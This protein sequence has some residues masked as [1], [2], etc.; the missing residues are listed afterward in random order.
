M[1][2]DEMVLGETSVDE[3]VFDE[4]SVD[5]MSCGHFYKSI[6]QNSFSA[7]VANTCRS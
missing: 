5:E 2:V 7:S 6:F 3:M 4:M 1:S